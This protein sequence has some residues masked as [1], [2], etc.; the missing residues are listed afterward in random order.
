MI[1]RIILFLWL[2]LVAFFVYRRYNQPAADT[3]LYKVRTLSFNK[4]TY[5]TSID[6]VTLSTSGNLDTKD[7]IWSL[8]LSRN[9][10]IATLIAIGSQ[11]TGSLSPINLTPIQEDQ[12]I[13]QIIGRVIEKNQT[14]QQDIIQDIPPVPCP[15]CDQ[16]RLSSSS[17]KKVTSS[18]QP[19]STST[20]SINN[21]SPTLS[22]QDQTE[23]EDF[24]QALYQD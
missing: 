19:N 5:T 21:T 8:L 24:L 7:T 6:G 9:A 16:A 18:P 20:T 22:S 13:D 23:A 12:A 14:W 17:V 3:L 10:T 11:T 2:L 4:S 1:R 15:E